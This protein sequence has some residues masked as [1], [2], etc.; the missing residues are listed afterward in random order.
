MKD[1]IETYPDNDIYIY[2]ERE[3]EGHLYVILYKSVVFKPFLAV[4]GL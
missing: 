4:D 2:R 1:N 3:R